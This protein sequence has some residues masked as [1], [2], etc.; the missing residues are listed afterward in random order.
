MYFRTYDRAGKAKRI[1]NFPQVRMT[2]C[3]FLGKVRG[4]PTS[5]T[6]RLLDGEDDARA[7]RLL[8]RWFP[9]LHGIAVP[10]VHR[11]KGWTTLHYEF[12]ADA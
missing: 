12:R 2:P 3:T 6:A 10:S 5:G 8:R 7:R 1:R 4:T 9:V 11:I